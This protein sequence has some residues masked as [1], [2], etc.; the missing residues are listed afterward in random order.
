MYLG[1]YF[2]A[3]RWAAACVLRHLCIVRLPLHTATHFALEQ[4][5]VR[6]ALACASDFNCQSTC[7]ILWSLATGGSRP[8]AALLDALA[9]RFQAVMGGA[10]AQQ[11]GAALSELMAKIQHAAA[12][13]AARERL[14]CTSGCGK[15]SA[16]IVELLLQG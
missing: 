9:A 16:V 6:R 1:K 8:R 12:V 7:N 14:V 10:S 11:M 13:L 3:P 15:M 4:V 2:H 5:M